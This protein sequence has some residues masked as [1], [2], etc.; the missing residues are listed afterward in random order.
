M[1]V[2]FNF[3]RKYNLIGHAYFVE[4]DLNNWHIPKC[5]VI[6][7]IFVYVVNFLSWIRE[8]IILSDMLR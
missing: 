5:V 8:Y 4:F 6:F 1:D 7:N 2:C 3:Y